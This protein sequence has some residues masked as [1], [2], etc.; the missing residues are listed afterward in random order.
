MSFRSYNQ[1]FNTQILCARNADRRSIW[2]T[3]WLIHH[4]VSLW[5]LMKKYCALIFNHWV[6]VLIVLRLFT[7]SKVFYVLHYRG[8]VTAIHLI[9]ILS[10]VEIGKEA[11]LWV[12]LGWRTLFLLDSSFNS[13]WTYF[14]MLLIPFNY[15]LVILSNNLCVH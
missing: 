14:K 10:F 5:V 6:W 11:M 2:N 15:D 3:T 7:T 12:M 9:Q 8:F 4:H 13:D 1:L